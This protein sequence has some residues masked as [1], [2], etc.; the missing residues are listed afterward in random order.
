MR[1]RVCHGAWQVGMRWDRWSDRRIRT[2]VSASCPLGMFGQRKRVEEDCGTEMT[3]VRLAVRD[4]AIRV[5]PDYS[6]RRSFWSA[7]GCVP[8]DFE[9]SSWGKE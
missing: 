9:S 6:L 7:V 8:E 1:T 5:P 4:G 2:L 3:P